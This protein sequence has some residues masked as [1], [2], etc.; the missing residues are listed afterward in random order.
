MQITD[1]KIRKII[2]S[3]NPMKAVVSIVVNDSIAIHDIKIIEVSGKQ[4]VAFCSQQDKQGNY[5]DIVHPISEKARKIDSDAV[6]PVYQEKLAEYI[7]KT[8]QC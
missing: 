4:F 6:L 1:V 3:D 8:A 2:V 5:R 7:I